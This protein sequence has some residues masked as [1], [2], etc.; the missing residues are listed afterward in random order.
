[1][2][3]SPAM[4]LSQGE[5]RAGEQKT[6]NKRVEFVE[7]IRA[8][9]EEQG[10]KVRQV[11]WYKDAFVLL[12][13][14]K[15]EL[16]E[17]EL[18]KQGKI[19]IQSL[20]SMVPPLVLGPLPGE[21][22]LDLTAAPGSKTSQMAMMMNK[23]GELFANDNNKV[24]FFKLKHNMELLGVIDSVTKTGDSVSE[25]FDDIESD[26]ESEEV[27]EGTQEAFEGEKKFC[28]L[29]LGD[30]SHLCGE[31]RDY[32][33]KIL[34]DA[35]CSAEARFIDGEPKSYG[36][37]SEKKIKEMA[38]KQRKLL[39]S[40]WVALRPGGTLVYS[41]CTFAPEENEVQVSKLV[42]RFP[43]EVEMLDITIDGLKILKPLKQWKE[44]ATH[45][46]VQK[47]VRIL[48]T[49]EIEGFFVAKLRKKK[50]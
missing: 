20:A 29:H 14:S 9:L 46:A 8:N 7:A 23:T 4:A 19:Y 18:Y 33:D 28:T 32:F 36:Y 41:T 1:M 17:T 5:W 25:V 31:H 50:I 39:F 40:A 26:D 11:P 15:R 37:W 38:Y 6:M 10:F 16:T 44:K 13:K 22:V 42:E 3:N 35:P 45:P 47:A 24:R 12:N 34:V 27:E 43:D 48:P 2:S 21:R 49:A 30:G